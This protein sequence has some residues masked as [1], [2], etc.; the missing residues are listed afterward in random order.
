MSN[1]SNLKSLMY[2]VAFI[3]LVLIAVSLVIVKIA[4]SVAGACSLIANV[5][6]YS[7]VAFFS[8]FFVRSKRNPVFLIT[9]IVCLVIVVV[10]MILI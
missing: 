3:G 1:K 9:W 7:M 8:F 5:I 10:M 2:L 6:A 4:P